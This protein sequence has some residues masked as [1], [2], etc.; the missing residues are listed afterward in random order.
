M[1]LPGNAL[2]F[3]L[4]GPDYLAQQFTQDLFSLLRLIVEQCVFQRQPQLLRDPEHERQI[5]AGHGLRF[6]ELPPKGQ[7]ANGA[8]A[9]DQRQGQH[10]GRAGILLAF[11]PQQRLFGGESEHHAILVE[12]EHQT[13]R[14]GIVAK[15]TGNGKRAVD[16]WL[17]LKLLARL[18]RLSSTVVAATAVSPALCPGSRIT[19]ASAKV[20]VA[21]T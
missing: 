11:A 18:R 19:P 6:T 9:G 15:L 13:M 10:D 17:R 3:G 8:L 5:G 21:T 16:L 1:E 14:Q 20:T 12:A 7:A 2:A 4:L